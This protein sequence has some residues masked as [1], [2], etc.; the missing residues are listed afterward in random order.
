LIADQSGYIISGLQ[1]LVADYVK[2]NQS[3]SGRK[4]VGPPSVTGA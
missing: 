2:K 4:Q 3:E 1:L